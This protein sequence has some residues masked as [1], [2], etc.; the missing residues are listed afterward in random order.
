MLQVEQVRDVRTNWHVMSLA[1]L[2]EGRDN[3][4]EQYKDLMQKAM[5]PARVCIAA[6]QAKGPEGHLPPYPAIA[7]PIHLE[8][9]QEDP[10]ILA[11]ALEEVGLPVDLAAAADSTEFD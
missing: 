1:V 3:L 7:N 11:E 8:Q 4:P 9:R 5:G 2:N 10:G 6:E